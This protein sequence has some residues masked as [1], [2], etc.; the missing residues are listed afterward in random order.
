MRLWA[1]PAIANVSANTKSRDSHHKRNVQQQHSILNFANVPQQTAYDTTVSHIKQEYQKQKETEIANL[2]EKEKE[3]MQKEYEK[4][5]KEIENKKNEQLRVN[6]DI[7]S[8]SDDDDRKIEERE[9]REKRAAIERIMR[10][11]KLKKERLQSEKRA[12][13]IKEMQ[14][15]KEKEIKEKKERDIKEKKEKEFKEEKERKE[16]RERLEKL[17][18]YATQRQ[19]MDRQHEESL[20]VEKAKYGCKYCAS[21]LNDGTRCP[22]SP[23]TLIPFC[24]RCL[25]LRANLRFSKTK[26]CMTACD[27]QGNI[28]A[29]VFNT[30]DTVGSLEG[31]AADEHVL[32]SRFG[33]LWGT[34][35]KTTNGSVYDALCQQVLFDNYVIKVKTKDNAN[36]CY[37]DETGDGILRIFAIRQILH[38]EPLKVYVS[39]PALHH[40]SS[41]F[42]TSKVNKKEKQKSTSARSYTEHAFDIVDQGEKRSKRF[43]NY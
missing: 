9:M 5:R 26:Q 7:D 16:K 42:A 13:E 1:T 4:T 22:N 30:G 29:V 28:H 8:S 17:E 31:Q 12:K 10:M 40:T 25:A 18:Q 32:K 43:K 35:T 19:E 15:Q 37:K 38:G 41:S 39:N 23:S 27:P 36:V 11:E 21:V 24:E 3:K 2:K 6:M 14:L 33:T 34:M 20:K